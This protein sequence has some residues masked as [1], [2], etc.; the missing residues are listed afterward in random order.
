MREGVQR[1]H[2]CL[3]GKLFLQSICLFFP[4]LKSPSFKQPRWRANQCCIHTGNMWLRARS[5]PTVEHGWSP[6]C[7]TA[8]GTLGLTSPARPGLY[9]IAG[10]C[11]RKGDGSR[12]L[13]LSSFSVQ[14]NRMHLHTTL[15]NYLIKWWPL[16]HVYILIYGQKGMQK[17][18]CVPQKAAEPKGVL[19]C[20]IDWDRK[21]TG[22]LNLDFQLL[23]VGHL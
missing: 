21:V 17:S 15:L 18:L 6:A 1:S 13:L 19:I 12:Q 4:L 9:Y 11:S 3:E 2:A 10:C 23:K 20:E 5:L 7:W 22:K 14:L 16:G 8:L